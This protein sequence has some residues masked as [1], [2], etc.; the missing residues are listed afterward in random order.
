MTGFSI[1]ANTTSCIMCPLLKLVVCL[2]FAF[3]SIRV[4][5]CADE[6]STSLSFSGLLVWQ[7]VSRTNAPKDVREACTTIHLEESTSSFKPD[8]PNYK[9]GNV[10]DFKSSSAGAFASASKSAASGSK[11]HGG[12][13]LDNVLQCQNDVRFCSEHQY[14]VSSDRI[15]LPNH[16]KHY[17]RGTRKYYNGLPE[18]KEFQYKVIN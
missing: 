17:T 2:F 11:S 1:H 16:L 8:S 9:A 5:I 18:L 7:D 15:H 14:N 4:Q 3:M 6:F 10:T 12:L 13:V